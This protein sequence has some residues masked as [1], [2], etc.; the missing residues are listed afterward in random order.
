MS[1]SESTVPELRQFCIALGREL[2]RTRQ[3]VSAMEAQLAL[4]ASSR[5][6]RLPLA[7]P[8]QYAEVSFAWVLLGQ[9]VD[10]FFVEAGAFDGFIFSVTYAL[11]AM[12]WNGLLV[13]PHPQAYASCAARRPFS[14]VVNA[15]LGPRGAAG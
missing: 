10:G 7:F 6:P 9:Q 15:I 2:A 1:D 4:Q 5:Q 3:K 13:E 12:G 14:R 8:A 11:E